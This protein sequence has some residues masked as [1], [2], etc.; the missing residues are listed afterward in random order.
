MSKVIISTKAYLNSKTFA[1]NSIFI[2]G[3]STINYIV[4]IALHK[5]ARDY[6]KNIDD[7]I[8]PYITTA[9]VF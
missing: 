5:N 1:G 2:I 9:N 4:L 6:F 8:F 7:N 3:K